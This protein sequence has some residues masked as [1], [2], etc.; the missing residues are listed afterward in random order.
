MRSKRAF[1]LVELLVV[2]GII[3]VLI[4]ILIPALSKARQQANLTVCMANLRSIGQACNIYAAQ[5][6]GVLPYGYWDG[7]APWATP[8]VTAPDFTKAGDWRILLLTAMVR[9]SSNTYVNNGAAGGDNTSVTANVFVDRDVPDNNRGVLTYGCHPRLMPVINARDLKQVQI[10]G[11][12]VYP[13]PY[14]MGRIKRASEVLLIADASL[15]VLP[16]YLPEIRYQSDAILGRLDH[17]AYLN[18]APVPTFL[19]DDLGLPGVLPNFGPSTPVDMTV[20]GTTRV[21]FD[22]L[23]TATA[24]NWSNIRFRHLN[25]TA[26]N[27]LMADGHVEA[28]RFDNRTK[29]TTLKRLNVNVNAQ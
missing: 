7:S 15:K 17:G 22:Q 20:D 23:D 3:A 24:L 13:K 10:N 28:H 12:S 2:I 27:V 6:K 4:G 1:T 25:N 16:D 26:A 19:L 18:P 11:K 5:H 29:I 21:N 8:A 9:Q 14:N